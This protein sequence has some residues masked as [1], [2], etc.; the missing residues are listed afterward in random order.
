[1]GI[2]SLPEE[3]SLVGDLHW[4]VTQMKN[5]TR[6]KL[7]VNQILFVVN[8]CIDQEPFYVYVPVIED[9]YGKQDF[10][11]GEYFFINYVIG[12]DY[13]A[14]E[15]CDEFVRVLK[16]PHTKKPQLIS[17]E[18]LSTIRD[19]IQEET[20]INPGN[21][22]RIIK[23]NLRG[24]HGVVNYVQGQEIFLRVRIGQETLDVNMPL[25]YTRRS[26]RKILTQQPEAQGLNL[27]GFHKENESAGKYN[28][29]EVPRLRILKKGLRRTTVL[30]DNK[31]HMVCN[32]E[33]ESLL[34]SQ[35]ETYFQFESFEEG[36]S[37]EPDFV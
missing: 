18:Q 22:V 12:V 37:Y 8:N 5:W 29:G 9:L 36:E 19:Q 28:F 13:Y 11:Y 31:I 2:Q 3:L 1:M 32:E 35:E 26:K 30:L 14:L 4:V 17:T 16:D 33:I 7:K 6:Y 25:Y 15:T 24:N 27:N 20:K 21:V 34:G 23:G 10:G